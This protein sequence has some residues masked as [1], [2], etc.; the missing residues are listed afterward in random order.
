LATILI[1][2]WSNS[3]KADS[4]APDSGG[5][6][7]AEIFVIMNNRISNLAALGLGLA[8]LLSV[9]SKARAQQPVKPVPSQPAPSTPA[10]SQ[11]PPAP[12]KES[13]P[14]TAPDQMLDV[15]QIA[16]NYKAG[17]PSL[18]ELGRVG[19]DLSQQRPLALREAIEM[20][21]SNNKDI[22][23]ARENVKIAEFDLTGA[24][25]AYDPRFSSLSYYERSTTASS[26]FLSGSASGAITQS[27][28]TGTARLEGISPSFGGSYRVDFSAIRLTT[29]N[30]FVALN[31]QFPSALTFNYTQPLIR[32][33]GFDQPRRQVEIAKK[34]LS[35]TDAQFRQRAI[36]SITNVQRAYWDLV[37]ALRNLQIQRDAVRDARTQVEHNKRLVAEGMLAPIDVVA[38]EAQVSGFEQ[39][40]YSALDDVGRAEN[41]LKGM[42]AENRQAP[43]WTQ[44]ILPTDPVDLQPPSVVPEEAVKTALENRP[45]VQ[46]SNVVKDI[47][48]LDQRYYREQTKPQV[49][50]VGT[51]GV[52]GLAGSLT[53]SGSNPL[54]ASNAQLL[55]RINLLSTING[56]QPL[57]ASAPLLLPDAVIGGFGQ[58]FLDLGANRYNNFRVGVQINLP[59][60]NRTAEA[61]LG[62]SLV[63]GQRIQTQREQLEQNIQIDVRNALQAVRTTQSRLRAAASARSASE[64]QYSSEQRRFDAGQSTLFLVLERQTALTTA[65]GNEL[66]AQTDLNKA[67]AD[68]QRATGNALQANNVVAKVR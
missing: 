49:D 65:R 63:E 14:S 7:K 17:N 16:P 30:T 40:V 32:G 62:H 38:A 46:Q 12:G 59:L 25:G 67:V 8:L 44:S 42:I 26:S 2:L 39:N 13:T 53:S 35:L 37:F 3:T 36:E 47:N 1:T 34:N 64:Q 33:L 41:T 43:I 21:L 22:E 50:L 15:P 52:T 23:L 29:N 31:P 55:N 20:A 18:P 11:N 9:S 45:E 27:D 5:G 61:Q 57:P 10:G 58:S 66:R 19:V 4:S 6:L 60:R 68:L 54:T 56:L 48:Q 24:R 28:V 51:Y